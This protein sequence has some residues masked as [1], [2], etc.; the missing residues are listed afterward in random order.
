MPPIDTLAV[1]GLDLPVSSVAKLRAAFKV[2]HY[3][4]DFTLPRDLRGEVDMVFANWRALPPDVDLDEC[5]RLK[6]IQ[7]STAGADMCIRVSPAIRELAQ[8]KLSNGVSPSEGLTLSNASGIHVLSIP[9][10]VTANVI[11]LY[12]QL[13][14]M[15]A[16]ARVSLTPTTLTR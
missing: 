5:T 14:V 11:V 3:R 13:Q 6:H 10:W 7:L 4:P 9:N 1:L 8:R 2:V 15:M 12:H 16:N